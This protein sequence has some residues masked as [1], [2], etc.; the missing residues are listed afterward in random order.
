[1][2]LR[3]RCLK[4]LEEE[5]GGG[6]PPGLNMVGMLLFVLCLILCISELLHCWVSKEPGSAGG[7]CA[8]EEKTES[9]ET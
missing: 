6:C 7:G 1:M 3:W 9:E 8:E 4:K 5:D 2:H